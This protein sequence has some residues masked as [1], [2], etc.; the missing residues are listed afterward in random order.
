MLK[1][2]VTAPHQA[3]R[4]DQIPAFANRLPRFGYGDHGYQA[5]IHHPS[6]A[7]KSRD[8]A[9]RLVLKK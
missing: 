4:R 2:V 6:A 1:G 8:L 5:S 9:D 3:D 7:R